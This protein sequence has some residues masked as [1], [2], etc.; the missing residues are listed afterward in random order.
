[1]RR[2]SGRG[3]WA[4]M[5][6]LLMAALLAAQAGANDNNTETW[7]KLSKR[8]LAIVKCMVEGKAECNGTTLHKDPKLWPTEQG[9][10][11]SDET[12]L[13]PFPALSGRSPAEVFRD[14]ATPDLSRTV[15]Q[16]TESP[17]Q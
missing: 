14:Y 16:G 10:A 13:Y 5:S 12:R 9:W 3:T 1:M 4:A 15:S 7:P 11:W 2:S 8:D 6:V 17:L